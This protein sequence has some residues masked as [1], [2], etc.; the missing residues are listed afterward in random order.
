M[1]FIVFF[2]L[3]EIKYQELRYSKYRICLEDFQLQMCF[4]PPS[5]LIQVSK[6]P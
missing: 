1:P 4:L 6:T 3:E 2:F 5:S